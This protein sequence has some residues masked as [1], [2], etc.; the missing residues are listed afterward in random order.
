VFSAACTI[1][2]LSCLHPAGAFL[3]S[4]CTRSRCA[5]HHLQSWKERRPISNTSNCAPS[6]P[7]LDPSASA[8][9]AV[10]FVSP[11]LESG[12]PPAVLEAEQCRDLG[13]SN[14]KPLL[15]YLPGFDGTLVAPFLQF[16]ELGTI[17]EVRGM[18]VP[19]DDRSTFQQL[20]DTVVEHLASEGPDRPVFLMGESFGGLLTVEVALELQS[21]TSTGRG[22]KAT[23][24]CGIVLVNP[25]TC[26]LRSSL[27]DLGP[28][29][30]ALPDW[31]YPIGV[32]SLLPLFVD[33]FGLSQ[34]LLILSSKALPSVIDTPAREAYMGR[35]AFSLP[36]KLKF[37][38]KDTLCWRLEEWLTTGNTRINGRE[39]K[40]KRVL[41]SLPVLVLAGEE[42]RTLPAVDEAQRLQGI[43][44]DCSVHYVDGAGHAGTCGSR[45]D[46]A[47]LMRNRFS[48]LRREKDAAT[49]GA[50]S[51]Y[52]DGFM[53]AEGDNG[54][55]SMKEEA[56]SGKGEYFGMTA[57]Y[58]GSVGLGLSPLK[59]WSHDL[60]RR[61]VSALP[62]AR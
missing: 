37:M 40:M 46:I 3:Q 22:S 19:M 26:Y 36:N 16:P 58:D 57:R 41:S 15:L 34:L 18:E 52:P 12:Y 23:N 4:R 20:R 32:A 2:L 35:T 38:P 6:K 11:L 43:L 1:V 5:N 24:L 29:V 33:D 14:P 9:H 56:A 59:Y 60:F 55:M 31:R 48:L 42:D 27:A 62:G 7:S 30:A 50:V 25:A 39:D 44:S 13:I 47:A 45:V 21:S 51:S 8:L 54:R 53:I 17:F 28:K 61:W 10:N 49:G